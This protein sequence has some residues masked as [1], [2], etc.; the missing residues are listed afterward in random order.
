[1]QLYSYY[2][3]AESMRSNI[4]DLINLNLQQTRK[5]LD[6]MLS[7]Y[8]DL[9]YQI[10]TDDDLVS[11]MENIGDNHEVAVNTNQ[12]R[13]RLASYSDAK[14]MIKCITMIA[15]NGTVIS[16]DK[17][18]PTSLKSSWLDSYAGEKPDYYKNIFQ[19]KDELIFSTGKPTLFGTTQN[20]LF[21]MAHRM[22]DYKSIYIDSGI[23]II[24]LDEGLLEDIGSDMKSGGVRTSVSYLV[25]ESGM[26]ISFP[27]QKQI[28]MRFDPGNIEQYRKMITDSSALRGN[29]ITISTLRD[30]LTGWTIVDAV[31]Q[32]AFFRRMAFQQQVTVLSILILG[33]ALIT[34][35][36]FLS[37]RLSSSIT[38]VVKAINM[39]G[40]GELS[41]RINPERKM[42][43]EMQV[44]ATRFNRMLSEINVLIADVKNATIKQKEA[45]IHALEAQINPHFI[46]NTLDTIN[47]MAI[48]R[49]QY[50]ISNMISS[51][52]KI[53]RYAV[54]NSNALVTMQ[55]EIE[56][57]RKYVF[58]QQTRLKFPFEFK[59][60]Y[61]ESVLEC[62]AHK[63]LIQPFVENAILHGFAG[64]HEKCLLEIC[65]R[66][67]GEWIQVQILDNGTGMPLET[68]DLINSRQLPNERQRSHIG[69]NN[70]QERLEMYYGENAS[71]SAQSSGNGTCITIRLPNIRLGEAPQ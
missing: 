49:S 52:A 44:I 61:D 33:V 4:S 28:G 19:S 66:N 18:S 63:L 41:V 55:D 56:W 12:L 64:Q 42:P 2:S 57:L 45:E 48:D 15:S 67:L 54:E 46:Y 62:L 13:R 70:V 20:Y 9:L 69:I 31:D 26:V 30:E 21:H 59:I 16:Y 17:L 5:S 22:I 25:N 8:N 7:G 32:S 24:S 65:I 1:V 14:P 11:N 39:A 35:I 51:L 36:I 58:L 50:E 68:I 43:A 6:L 10:Y 29:N 47:W 3:I 71:I 40:G 27:D 34:I 37:N 38:K 53:L 60:E 23:A